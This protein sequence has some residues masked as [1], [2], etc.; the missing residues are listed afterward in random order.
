MPDHPLPEELNAFLDEASLTARRPPFPR[1]IP[2]CAYALAALVAAR[3]AHARLHVRE[4]PLL[5]E[6]AA[7]TG[8]SWEQ[9]SAS[10]HLYSQHIASV[11]PSV[12]RYLPFRS[13]CLIQALAARRMLLRRCLG[14]EIRIGVLKR[15]AASLAS[16]AW[17][18]A[19]EHVVIGGD[20][21]DYTT[22]MEGSG[23]ENP[24]A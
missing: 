22:V 4:L 7:A 17:L 9:W 14:S 8:K 21:A 15:D 3:R 19:G 24:S 16:H 2:L 11:V 10:D 6:N 13:D 1:L 18:V 20:V 23:P 5:N 12:A